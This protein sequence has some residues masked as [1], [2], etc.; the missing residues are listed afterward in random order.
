MFDQEPLPL[1]HPLRYCPR[2][3]VTPHVGYASRENYAGY[4]REVVEDIEGWLAGK[5]VR[6]LKAG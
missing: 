6:V 4:F 5:P 2:L 3:V 1:H